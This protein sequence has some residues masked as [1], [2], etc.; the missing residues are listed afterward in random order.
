MGIQHQLFQTQAPVSDMGR[1]A[2]K[3]QRDLDIEA[4][5]GYVLVGPVQT[6]LVGSHVIYTAT[7]VR[8]EKD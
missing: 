2:D 4:K 1:G 5:K 7:M 6:L 3:M 8:A